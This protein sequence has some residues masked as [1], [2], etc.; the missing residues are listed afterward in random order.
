MIWLIGNRGMLGTDVEYKLKANGLEFVATDMDVDITDINALRKFAGSR[1]IDWIINCSAYTAVDKAEDE[2]DK[3]FSINADGAGNIALVAKEKTAKLIH[4]S[5]DY[6][7]DGKKPEAYNEDDDACPIGVYGKS[8]LKG[9][10]N[11]LTHCIRNISS[12]A[13]HGFTG[14]TA[15]IL[16]TQCS[17]LSANVMNCV[18]SMISGEVLLLQK[19]LRM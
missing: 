6:V 14:I 12:S 13:F 5:T 4:V 3:A 11:V 19:T 8:K 16:F 15:L 9:E 1:K 18:L 17:G 2:P 10:E 7:F